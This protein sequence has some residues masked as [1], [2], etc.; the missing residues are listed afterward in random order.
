M[1][2]GPRQREAVLR[3]GRIRVEKSVEGQSRPDTDYQA[4]FRRVATCEADA[5]VVKDAT[6]GMRRDTPYG[7]RSVRHEWAWGDGGF[8]NRY[9]VGVEGAM[10]GLRTAVLR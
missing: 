7:S 9:T 8:C 6:M 2:N 3:E 4:C 10:L 1:V 5:N